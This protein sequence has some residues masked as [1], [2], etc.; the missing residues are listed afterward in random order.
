MSTAKHAMFEE[1]TLNDLAR[2]ANFE[3]EYLIR[4]IYYTVIGHALD[5]STGD[6]IVTFSQTKQE[7]NFEPRT[8]ACTLDQWLELTGKERE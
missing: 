4:E 6:G 3:S 5:Y 1:M 7:H 2:Y 8:W